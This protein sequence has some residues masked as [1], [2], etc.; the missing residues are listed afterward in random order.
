MG[1]YRKNV[2][3]VVFNTKGQVLLGERIGHPGNFQF[4]QGGLD[5]GEDPEAAARR[6]LH[7]EVGLDLKGPCAGSIDEW[8]KYDFPPD[9]RKKFDKHVGQ[10]QR[11][12]FFH[13]DGDP[14][15]LPLDLHKPEFERLKWGSL[16]EAV[17][18]IVDFKRPVY[19]E[20]ARRGAELIRK[21]LARENH[22]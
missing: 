10:K 11:W 4:P 20:V 13:W 12:F 19:A 3:M 22:A 17:A 18:G 16:E 2:G 15:A 6:E 5:D 14:A 21:A 9:I 1:K 8:L 7:E